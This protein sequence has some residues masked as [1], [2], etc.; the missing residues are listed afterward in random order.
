L[1]RGPGGS[2]ARFASK[3]DFDSSCDFICNSQ[4]EASAQ[5]NSAVTAPYRCDRSD[6]SFLLTGKDEN[7][8]CQLHGFISRL[9]QILKHLS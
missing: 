6:V 7:K 9:T 4:L 2:G 1:S 8:D 3:V 5:R